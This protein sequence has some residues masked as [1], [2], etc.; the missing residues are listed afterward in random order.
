MCNPQ[1]LQSQSL[2]HAQIF[3]RMQGRVQNL[4]VQQAESET[5][6]GRNNQRQSYHRWGSRAI[7]LLGGVALRSERWEGNSVSLPA[8]RA[9]APVLLVAERPGALSIAARSVPSPHA[10]EEARALR[11]FAP[12]QGSEREHYSGPPLLLDEVLLLSEQREKSPQHSKPVVLEVGTPRDVIP[13]GI[14]SP[15]YILERP[16]TPQCENKLASSCVEQR[17]VSPCEVPL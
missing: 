4:W 15:R 14:Y 12:R 9:N 1:E 11:G 6:D 3:P 7:G 16:P 2:V 17:I 10:K 8:G 5:G 13:F